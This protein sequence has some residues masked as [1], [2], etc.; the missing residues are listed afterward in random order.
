[1]YSSFAFKDSCVSCALSC[2]TNGSSSCTN[3]SCEVHWSPRHR[4]AKEDSFSRSTPFIIPRNKPSNVFTGCNRTFSHCCNA[5]RC[6]FDKLRGSTSVP[7]FVC[8]YC[9]QSWQ[10]FT[11]DSSEDFK[12]S[13]ICL[14][15]DATPYIRP[16]APDPSAV[17][18]TDAM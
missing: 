3:S 7:P 12:F 16:R 14:G 9:K 18:T 17:N 5:V 2:S 4:W 8:M 1:M 10:S 13:T 11:R 6:S 15:A